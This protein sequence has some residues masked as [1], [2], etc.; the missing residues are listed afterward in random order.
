M[1][2][3]WLPERF[4]AGHNAAVTGSLKVTKG[5]LLSRQNDKKDGT[6]EQADGDRCAYCF[7]LKHEFKLCWTP[8]RLMFRTIGSRWLLVF[9][10]WLLRR[11][12]REISF[13][14]NPEN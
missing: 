8:E 1:T 13:Y 7:H 11:N 5:R 2:A 6:P 14:G 3:E 4:T 10:F 9:S 12:L